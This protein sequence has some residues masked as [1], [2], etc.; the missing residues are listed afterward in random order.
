MNELVNLGWLL[1]R[2]I[3]AIIFMIPAGGLECPGF[4]VKTT[5]RV[6][7]AILHH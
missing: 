4:G 1:H 6:N 5:L 2:P 3:F 7:P